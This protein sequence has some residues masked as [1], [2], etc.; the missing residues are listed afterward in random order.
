MKRTRSSETVS[1][2]RDLAQLLR[3]LRAIRRERLDEQELTARMTSALGQAGS[4]SRFIEFRS[5]RDSGRAMACV[6]HGMLDA[7]E[8]AYDSGVAVAERCA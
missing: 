8:A 6:N 1:L 5:S 7:I 3:R 2:R 4:I